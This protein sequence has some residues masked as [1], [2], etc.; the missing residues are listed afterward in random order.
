M[1]RRVSEANTS[2]KRHDVRKHTIHTLENNISKEF[3]CKFEDH[4]K[5]TCIG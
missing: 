1:K 2:F 3:W 5:R 4:I